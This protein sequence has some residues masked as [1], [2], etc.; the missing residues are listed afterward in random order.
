MPD[1]LPAHRERGQSPAAV[2]EGAQAAGQPDGRGPLHDAVQQDRAPHAEDD[3]HGV[4]RQLHR[5]RAD[6]HAGE[7]GQPAL[8]HYLSN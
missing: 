2:R 5:E 6:A 1:A 3:H 4:H 7:S 8:E